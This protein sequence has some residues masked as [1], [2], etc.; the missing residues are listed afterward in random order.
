MNRLEVIYEQAYTAIT[1]KKMFETLVDYN[2]RNNAPFSNKKLR[3]AV[4]K[5]MAETEEEER[6]SGRNS[7]NVTA[8]NFCHQTPVT[9]N[10][11]GEIANVINERR[12]SSEILAETIKGQQ[13]YILQLRGRLRR[14]QS[15]QQ[16]KGSYLH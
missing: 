13:F 5:V 10:K 7:N 12:V 4:C 16:Y 2:D 9:T 3:Q 15:K 11:K 14:K 1:K 6:D 8:Y